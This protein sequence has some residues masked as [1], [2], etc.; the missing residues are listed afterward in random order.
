M[1]R[2]F[3]LI[4]RIF[5]SKLIN[6]I[7]KPIPFKLT[8]APTFLCNSRCKTCNIWKIYKEKPEKIY[9][10]LEFN[11]WKRLF[12]EI[13]NNLI[14]VEV[15]GGEPTLCSNIDR[16]MSYIYRKT[17]IVACGLTTNG[18]FPQKALKI[19][20]NLLR[21]IPTHK[22]LVVGISLD[23]EPQLHDT[24]RGVKG[25][26]EKA[27]WL[28]KNLKMLKENHD[29]L[30]IHFSYTISRY[31]AG[32][33][34]SFYKFLRKS[35]NISITDITV[36]LEHYTHF[37]HK[38]QITQINPYN[39]FYKRI[40]D[41]ISTYLRLFMRN[42]KRIDGVLN[43]AR[44]NFYRFYIKKIPAFL[45]NPKK[46]IIPCTAGTSSAYID[47]YGNVYPCTSWALVLGNLK[48]HSFREIWWSNLARKVRKKIINGECVNCWTPC[49]AQPSWTYN[50][51]LLRGWK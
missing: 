43:K 51:G 21:T 30:V 46:M 26:F 12:D 41:D 42:E 5:K 10:E 49:E 33:F 40:I 9:D 19:I 35:Q 36:T 13:G 38:L 6:T 44:F 15:T 18:I 24:I 22:T 45:N 14:W 28:Y 3:N 29:N 47:P 11:S 34:N 1:D 50:L 25:S 17:G 8:I 16:I 20:R 2:N 48:K 39:D 31:N 32:K 37:Y 4:T 27:L 7:G 23:G